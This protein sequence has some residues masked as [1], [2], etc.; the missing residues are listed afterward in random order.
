MGNRILHGCACAGPPT[1]GP[2]K[3]IAAILDRAARPAARAIKAGAVA[4][5]NRRSP[6]IIRR[7]RRVSR[8]N[9]IPERR[10]VDGRSARDRETRRVRHHP[11]DRDTGPAAEITAAEVGTPQV[12]VARLTGNAPDRSGPE[13]RG[14]RRA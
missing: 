9:R 14:H 6:P 13:P 11:V 2:C 10:A 8:Q 3:A 5:G 12:P 4:R 7:P 1:T